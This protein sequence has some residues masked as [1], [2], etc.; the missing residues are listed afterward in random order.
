[1]NRRSLI[2]GAVVVASLAVSAPAAAAPAV[3]GVTAKD[4]RMAKDLRRY[5][6]RNFSSAA[7]YDRI[8][9]YRVARGVITV[10]TTLKPPSRRAAR[11]ICAGIQASDLADFKPGH[12]V[13]GRGGAVLRRCAART[14]P[15]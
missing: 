2:A 5:F 8:T 15:R 1:M 9:V 3:D 4:Q 6:E 13:T 14:H 11:R 12:R 10:R 7:W